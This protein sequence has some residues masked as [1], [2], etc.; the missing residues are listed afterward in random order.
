MVKTSRAAFLFLLL[1]NFAGN[2]VCDGF[3]MGYS[4]GREER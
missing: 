2:A 3:G 4:K 1:E